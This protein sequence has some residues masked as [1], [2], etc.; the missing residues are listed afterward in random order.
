[1]TKAIEFFHIAEELR[2][3]VAAEQIIEAREPA[4]ARRRRA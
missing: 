4:K 2:F 1:V 3:R